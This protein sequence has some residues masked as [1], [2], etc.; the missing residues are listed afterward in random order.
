MADNPVT[1]GTILSW[2][3]TN[4]T[5]VVL[6]ALVAFGLIGLAQKWYQSRQSAS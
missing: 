5:T 2:N 6:M 3:F 1:G 4:W